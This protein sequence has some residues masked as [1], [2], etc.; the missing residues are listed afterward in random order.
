MREYLSYG[1]GVGSTGLLCYLLPRIRNGE[2]EVVFCDHGGDYPETYQYVKYIQEAL[3]IH[4]TVLKID[5]E[6][7]GN[8]YEYFKHYEMI[9]LYRWRI[10]TVASK[11]KP[12]NKY[13]QTPCISY[14]G[15]T[16]DERKRAKPNKNPDIENKYPMVE[17]ELTREDAISLI[18]KE[19]LD[20][21]MRSGCWFCPFQG[22]E[23]W[24]YLY[25]KHEDLFI[26]AVDLE[27]NAQSRRKNS[28]ILPSGKPLKMLYDEFKFQSKLDEFS[29]GC[30]VV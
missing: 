3:G 5:I 29:C 26:K 4:I 15:I 17:A 18:K 14:Q 1:G 13:V 9:P 7:K 6:G 27:E 8:L 25:E 2:I 28:R 11:I 30:G 20:V 23:Q 22:R 19:G 21:P 16:W 10:C 12:F 24:R